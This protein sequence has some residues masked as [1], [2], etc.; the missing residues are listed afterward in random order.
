MTINKLL[1]SQPQPISEKSPFD[2]LVVTH[3]AEIDFLPFMTVVGVSLKEFIAQ[4][5]KILDHSVVIFTS[6][7]LIDNFF[8]L[9]GE[10][11]LTVPDTMKYFCISE[12][13]ANYLQKYILYRKRKIFF[14]E[15]SITSL[16]ELIMHH[17]SEKFLLPVSEPHKPEIILALNRASLHYTKVVFSHAVCTDLSAV[18]P[19][20]YDLVALYSPSEIESFKTQMLDRGYKGRLA[21]FGT[22]VARAVIDRGIKVDVMAPTEQFPSMSAALNA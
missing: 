20:T 6:R 14:A 21:V 18:D 8:R 5:V 17:T 11:R 1:I 16:I 13:I 10:S 19:N 4:R 15:S 12:S 2:D 22:A 3:N 7:T 9:V